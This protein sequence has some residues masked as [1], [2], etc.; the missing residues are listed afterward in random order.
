MY[1][2]NTSSKRIPLRP[3]DPSALE[4][5]PRRLRTRVLADGHPDLANKLTYVFGDA[6]CVDCGTPFHV[7]EAVVAR[8]G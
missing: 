6:V 8:W 5:L 3:A 2:N 7:H 1:M 4:G